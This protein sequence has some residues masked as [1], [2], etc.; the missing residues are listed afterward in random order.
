MSHVTDPETPAGGL[1]DDGDT[2]PA[3][4][5]VP[6][7]LARLWRLR[8]PSRLGRR[9]VLDVDQVVGAA[10]RLADRDGLAGVTLP[11]VGEALGVTP[12]S[13]YR[14]VGSKD[15]LLVLMA[16]QASSPAD[17]ASGTEEADVEGDP[18]WRS[19]L[20]RWAADVRAMY[21]RHPWL[22]H[23]PVQGPPSG[24]H[25]LARMDAGLAALR[26][27]ELD[28]AAKVGVVTLVS[29]Y[30]RTASQLAA[31]LSAARAG[32]G[33]DQAQSEQEYGRAM[34]RLVRPDRFPEVTALFGSGLFEQEP[35]DQIAEE[36][37]DHD[38]RFGLETILD[39]VAVAVERSAGGVRPSRA[40][41][42]ADRPGRS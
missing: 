28:W 40:R 8:T 26:G 42:G 38:F 11:K 1:P 29:G 5:D 13:L 34:A 2:L 16:D 37:P 14:Y 10:I 20:R 6:A 7:G 22:V 32:S 17:A 15:E 4:D 41:P 24:P 21:R 33:L 9:A 12:M 25:G 36:G 27:T 31:D 3:A 18:A 23:L 30:V 35:P 39:G 19:A